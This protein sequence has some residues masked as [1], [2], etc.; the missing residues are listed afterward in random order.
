MLRSNLCDY[1]DAYIVAKGRISVRCANNANRIN[2]Q[3]PFKNNSVLR[4]CISKIAHL[5]TMQKILTLL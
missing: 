3:L 1:N 5:L 4:S 2:K